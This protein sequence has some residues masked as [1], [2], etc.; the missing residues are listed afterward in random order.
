MASTADVGAVFAALYAAHHIGDFWV[1]TDHQARTKGLPGRD[2]AMACLAHVVS[3]T[4]TAV[5]ALMSMALVTGWSPAWGH[6]VAGLAVSAVS[7]Y[8][9]D[10][11]RPLRWLA[12]LA[13]LHLFWVLGAP[14]PDHNDKPCLGTGAYALD[15]SFHLGW[16]F[17]AALI[18]A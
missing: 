9:A 6:L 1:Q 10:R 2:G 3:Y 11:R 4:L 5:I 16:I 8:V 17:V 15:Q 13:G 7:H 12:D 18:I 14:R